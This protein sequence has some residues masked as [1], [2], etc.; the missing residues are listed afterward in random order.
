MD[1]KY[2]IAF[3]W[4][5]LSQNKIYGHWGDGLRAAISIIEKKHKIIYLEPWQDIP[6]EVDVILYWEA[7]VT[8]NGKD[9]ENY[10]KVK[11]SKKPKILLFAGGRIREDE[12]RGFD[13]FLVESRIN[14]QELSDIAVPWLRAFGVDTSVMK[15]EKQPKVFDAVFP[16]TCASWKRQGLFSRA[17]KDKGVI[18]GRFQESDPIG[19]LS[20]RENNTMVFPELPYE[21]VNVLYNSSWCC[22]NTSSEWGGGQRTTLE[23]MA[24]GIPVIVMSD[25]IKNREYVEESGAGIV[26]EPNEEAIRRGIEEVKKWTLEQRARGVEYVRSKW[27]AQHYADNIMKG[28]NQVLNV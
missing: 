15:P 1:R 27:T 16:A 6:D 5:G 28:I 22:V 7:P 26:V 24:A 2:V 18:C 10:L 19:F 9:R 21:A 4:Q 3:I 17:L 25:S 13:L 11:N 12:C 20:A 14:E 8:Q 23:A